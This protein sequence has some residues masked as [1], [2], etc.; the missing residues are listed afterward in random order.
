M[1]GSSAPGSMKK[2]VDMIKWLTTSDRD[3]TGSGKYY[4]AQGQKAVHRSANDE[5]VQEEFLRVCE[6]ISGV[7]LP[8]L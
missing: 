1:G 8:K 7:S 3:V 5:R 6:D 4:A 2:A